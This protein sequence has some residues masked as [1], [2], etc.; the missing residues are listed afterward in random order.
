MGAYM[1]R[2]H[3]IIYFKYVQLFV[4]QLCLYKG[5]EEKLLSYIYWKILDLSVYILTK[6]GSQNFV[7]FL[8][9]HEAKSENILSLYI[10]R[11]RNKT[12]KKHLKKFL[13]LEL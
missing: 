2:M 9:L 5:G 13:T 8:N 11:N 4:R 12:N 3:L 7:H 1:C 6:F 10:D